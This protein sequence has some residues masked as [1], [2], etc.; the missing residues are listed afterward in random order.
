MMGVSPITARPIH[1]VIG[2]IMLLPLI[3]WAVTGAVF[4]IKPGYGA[5]YDSLP[6]RTYPLEGT[7]AV[8]PD[9]SWREV[10][11]LRTILGLHLLARTDKGWL[12][13]DPATLRPA[14]PPQ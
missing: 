1:R 7:I 8:R 12:Q 5:A 3:T 4:F 6:V 14:A 11:H 13:F 10:R 9:P 2:I